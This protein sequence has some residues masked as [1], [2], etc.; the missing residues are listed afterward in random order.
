MTPQTMASDSTR[1]FNHFVSDTYSTKDKYSELHKGCTFCRIVVFY[2]HDV[3]RTSHKLHQDWKTHPRL[4]MTIRFSCATSPLAFHQVSIHSFMLFYLCMFCCLGRP[5][6]TDSNADEAI[7]VPCRSQ[8]YRGSILSSSIRWQVPT[9]IIACIG[10][11]MG[12]DLYL[13]V[14]R[15]VI[16]SQSLKQLSSSTNF[17]LCL[18]SGV[19]VLLQSCRIFLFSS[20]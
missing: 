6:W 15:A 10:S 5:V 2:W 17:L 11:L 1:G 9:F 7:K 18:F 13:W 12:L 14:N 20:A 19:S 8:T 16:E 4:K 3:H